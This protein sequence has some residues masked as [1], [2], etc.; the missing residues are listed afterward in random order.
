VPIATKV[1]VARR[2]AAG[3][4]GFS[5]IASADLRLKNTWAHWVRPRDP[6]RVEVAAGGEPAQPAR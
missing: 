2:I 6:G 4:P 1:E 3:H 5:G